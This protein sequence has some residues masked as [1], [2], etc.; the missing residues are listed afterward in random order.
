MLVKLYSQNTDFKMLKA[1]NIY[2]FFFFLQT[3]V[4]CVLISFLEFT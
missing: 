4:V 3:T 1:L 2:R